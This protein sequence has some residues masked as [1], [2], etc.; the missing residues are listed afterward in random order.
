MGVDCVLDSIESVVYKRICADNIVNL[1][2]KRTEACKKHSNVK[3]AL[4]VNRYYKN[5]DS[6]ISYILPKVKCDMISYSCYQML[7][8]SKDLYD[9]ITRIKSLMK[10]NMELYIGEFGYPI[11]KDIKEKV[12]KCMN[13][14]IEVFVRHRIRLAFY[15]NLYCN[16]KKSD[17]T[18]NGFGIIT[19]SGEITYVYNELF[20]RKACIL[21]RHG[22]SL[23]N[24]WKNENNSN[25]I[26]KKDAE[27]Y[28]LIDSD[29]SYRGIKA[30]RQ[31]REEFWEHVFKNNTK[32]I[33]VYI[34]PLK[35]AIRTFVKVLAVLIRNI[36]IILMLL[37]LL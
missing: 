32:D 30:I 7:Y 13:N 18:F 27:L 15:W 11:N 19:P 31:R 16:E 3:I 23:A 33:T 6:S 2:N 4:E 9:N 12:L 5:T 20:N 26:H 24:D 25:Y 36:L 14:S 21:V 29:L 34:S 1:I 10:P 8:N 22:I 28:N 17:G 37:L 35:R